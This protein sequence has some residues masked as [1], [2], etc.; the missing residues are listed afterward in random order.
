MTWLLLS[1]ALSEVIN[2]APGLLRAPLS[3]C[4]YPPWEYATAS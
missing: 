1:N 2:N 4:S 3:S